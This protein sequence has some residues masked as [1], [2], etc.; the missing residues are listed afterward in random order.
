MG[1][2]SKSS[3]SSSSSGSS[4][5]GDAPVKPIRLASVTD[6]SSF[7][8][9]TRGTIAEHLRF[10]SRTVVGRTSSGCRQTVG[11]SDNPFLVHVYVRYDGLAGVVVTQKDYNVRV[12]YSLINKMM[13][14]YE[15][16]YPAWKRINADQDV[17]PAAM[18][19][20]IQLYQNPAEAD[21]LTA[22]QK[23][24]DEVKDIMHKNIEQVLNRGETLDSLMEKSDDLS[25]TSHAFYKNAKKQ[26]QCCKAY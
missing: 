11:L 20:D 2:G 17:E 26:N 4:S 25:V 3:S 13:H 1:D 18:K 5:S 8:Y 9:F 16:Q 7:N 15:Q 19:K 24:L 6:L 23:N 21:K 22:I 10:A 12:A 14:D